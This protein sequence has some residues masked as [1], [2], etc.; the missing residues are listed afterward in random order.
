MTVLFEKTRDWQVLNDSVKILYVLKE[1]LKGRSLFMK[2]TDPPAEFYPGKTGENDIEFSYPPA[3]HLNDIFTLY[4]T[5][6]RQLEIDFKKETEV[7][8]GSVVAVPIEARIGKAIRELVRLAN[9]SGMVFATN[10]QV[11]KG[12]VKLDSTSQISNRIIFTEMERTLS[13][14]F[15][16]AQVVDVSDTSKKLEELKYVPKNC[17]DVLF[18]RD[19]SRDDSYVSDK[20]GFV[21]IKKALELEG[22]FEKLKRGYMEKGIRS[23]LCVPL[24]YDVGEIPIAI[25]H[26]Y[27]RSEGNT[28]IDEAI[29]DVMKQ[30]AAEM[31]NRV[32]EANTIVVPERQTIENF[33]E[34]GAA[35]NIDNE[36]LQKYISPKNRLTFD[37]VFRKQAPIRLQGRVCHIKKLDKRMVVGVEFE[38]S[39]QTA[40]KTAAM[41]RLR[42]LV[43]IFRKQAS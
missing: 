11:S 42:S 10:F 9:R 15:L 2:N 23:V 40:G 35:I 5:I 21:S 38:G 7:E 13:R 1:K 6:G 18:I 17:T 8:K 29:V 12:E 22:E 34:K 16:G 14:D 36:E 27:Y 20:P 28:E 30:K 31:V 26:I 3:Q 33:H 4:T 39:A 19:V 32:A 37:L 41:D 43:D 25:A 24:L